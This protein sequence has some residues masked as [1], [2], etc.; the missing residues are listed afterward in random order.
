[1]PAQRDCTVVG[2]R[3]DGFEA[4]HEALPGYRTDLATGVIVKAGSQGS[5]GIDGR[6]YDPL[7]G[8]C[9]EHRAHLA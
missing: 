3:A 1:V 5:Q 6:S 8:S 4:L 7:S 2:V 9:N